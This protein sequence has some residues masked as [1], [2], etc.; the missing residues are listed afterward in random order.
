ME[1][2]EEVYTEFAG[3]NIASVLAK[4]SGKRLV[5]TPKVA[6]VPSGIIL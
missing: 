2:M 4:L 1:V 5:Y 3:S 6:G